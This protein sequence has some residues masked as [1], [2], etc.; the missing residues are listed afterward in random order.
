LNGGGASTYSWSG[1]VTNGV[2]FIPTA[3]ATYTVTGTSS[4]G[5]TNT[6]TTA[7]ILD[8]LPT[9]T[10][11]SSSSSVCAG[12]SVSLNGGG[13][14]TYSW[15]GGVTNG[16]SFIPT[17]TATYTVTGTSA[18]GC[19]NTAA[20]TVTV[21]ALP[22]LVI[23]ASSQLYCW[24]DA[25]GTLTANPTGG[26]WSGTGVSGNSFNPTV[27]GLGSFNIVYTYSDANG[28]S[29]T[30]T[31]IM[32]VTA[33]VGIVEAPTASLFSVYPNPTTSEINVTTDTQLIGSDYIICD[34]VGKT[35]LTGKIRGTNTMI[36]L[37]NFSSGVYLLS[38]GNH[39]NLKQ[40]IK[41]VKE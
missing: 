16:V 32:T 31:L 8:T 33:C 21:N 39:S 2:S 14:T 30:D 24:K 20:T 17:A 35:I 7:V 27:A 41:V 19:T 4:A 12:T 1:G 9:V 29:N 23:S 3:T 28:C 38:I 40:S 15:S 5:C 13:A 37:S 6:A 10:A 25:A 36:K 18:A 22:V 11:T 34:N 26:V